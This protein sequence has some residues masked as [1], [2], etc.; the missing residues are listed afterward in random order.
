MPLASKPF[1]FIAAFCLS[2]AATS[3][4]LRGKQRSYRNH[5]DQTVST[6]ACVMDDASNR[7]S[8]SQAVRRT[9][10][11]MRKTE[12]YRCDR[13]GAPRANAPFQHIQHQSPEKQFFGKGNE[14]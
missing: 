6:V 9:L 8:A 11:E 5:I 14:E 3:R 12:E 4:A 2:S 13:Q 1:A 10:V 7:R